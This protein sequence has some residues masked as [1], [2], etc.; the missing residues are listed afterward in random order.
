MSNINYRCN[1][2]NL[3]LKFTLCVCVCVFVCLCVCGKETVPGNITPALLKQTLRVE[4]SLFNDAQRQ[5]ENN[6][7]Q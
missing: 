5:Q 6:A 2:S 7:H 3:C 4:Q 1:A